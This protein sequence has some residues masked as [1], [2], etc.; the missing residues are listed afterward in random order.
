MKIGK[1]S[2]T[3]VLSIALTGLV[4]QWTLSTPIKANEEAVKTEIS[5]SGTDLLQQDMLPTADSSMLRNDVEKE[6]TET[7]QTQ[8]EAEKETEE[9]AVF[10]VEKRAVN[11]LAAGTAEVTDWQTFVEALADSSI[12]T[13]SL[14]NDIQ[15]TGTLNNYEGL[16]D[17]DSVNL[18]AGNAFLFVSKAAISRSLVIDGNGYTFDF[19]NL[20]IGFTNAATN[21]SSYWD[22]TL[23]NITVKSVNP[24]APFYYPVLP[25]AEAGKGMTSYLSNSRLT[26]GENFVHIK[27]VNDMITFFLAYANR[28]VTEI[29]LANDIVFPA[30]TTNLNYQLPNINNV[31]TNIFTTNSMSN[32]SGGTTFLYTNVSGAARAFTLE[33]NG[34]SMDFGT[35][36]L[37]TLNSTLND[38][39]GFNLRWH[40]TYQNINFFHGNYWGPIE[41]QDLSDVYEREC[42]Q[43]FVDV[44]DYGAQFVQA[45]ASTL[46]FGGNIH[47]EQQ[48]Y[49]R[50]VGKDGNPLRSDGANYD[51][52]T[53]FSYWRVNNSRNQTIGV[54]NV[55][56]EDDS[57]IFLSSIGGVVVDLWS[58][59]DMVIGK[60]VQMDAVR[61][62][63]ETS[64]EGTAAVFSLRGGSISIGEDSVV[65]L[66]SNHTSQQAVISLN[67]A[68]AA[69]DV[70]KG[71]EV[72]ILQTAN[73]TN[74]NGNTQNA[75]YMGGGSIN[76]NGALNVNGT[77]MG[78]SNSHMIYSNNNVSF[79]IAREGTLDIQSDSTSNDQRLIYMGGSGS[80]FQFSDAERVN[81]QR[82]STLT[83]G[84]STNNGLIYSGGSLEVSVQN[85][86]QWNLNNMSG[87]TTAD[88][89]YDFDYVPMSSMVLR[90]GNSYNPTI[91]SANSMT[92]ATLNSFKENFTTRGQQRVLFTRIPDPNV[93]IHSIS[94]DNPDDPGS[95]TVYGYAVP[96]TYIRLWEEALNGT[97]SAKEKGVNDTIE[98]PV[99]DTG[100]A[101]ET[102]DNFT[103]QA[104]SD[105]NWSYTISSGN[106]FTAGNVIHAYGFANLKSE[107]PTQVVLDKTPPT[108]TPVT[109]YISQGD[110]LPDPSAFVKDA[111]DT[112]PINT[113]FDYAYTDEAEAEIQRNTVGTHTIK[114]NV[115]DRAT[116]ADGNAAPNTAVIE[117]TLIV[118]EKASGITADDLEVAYVDIR[119]LTDAELAAYIL[120]NSQPEAFNIANG[121]FTDL[122]EYV[123]VSDFGGLNE[124]GNL[125][126]DTPYVVTLTVPANAE[127]GLS[128]PLTTTIQVVVIN[129]DAVLTVQFEDESGTVLSGYTLT[130]GEGQT[131]DTALNVGDVIDLTSSEFQAVQDQLT[132][133]ETAGYE[134]SVRPENETNFSITETAQTVTY[135]V[136]G[137]LFLKSAPSTVDFG[138]ITYNAKVQRVDNPSTDGDLVVTDTRANQADGWTLYAALT[139][140]MK[141]D[142][143]GSVMNEALWYVDS[144]G[145]EISLTLDSGNQPIYTNASGGTFDVTG[146]WGDTSADPGL[147]LVAD[148]TKTTVSSIGTYSGVVTWTIM[149]GQP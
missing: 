12:T 48:E 30:G 45:E 55:T 3:A 126:P 113:G 112:S 81:L 145:E 128:T 80:T 86:F 148:P 83:N 53:D 14:A 136:T 146:T 101:Q 10:P 110:D 16:F 66:T 1:K 100:M 24:Y 9:S 87:G 132:A 59:G 149:A 13:I 64:G 56:F 4:F 67:S 102:R 36:T 127:T 115:S 111:A 76:V 49:Y 122:T 8:E 78:S 23:Q 95:Y 2:L 22:I 74:G 119:D 37:C 121:T 141:N 103:V 68:S 26:Y 129:M 79:V 70:S 69:I 139:T 142:E 34:Y 18:A 50:S 92:N 17:K 131:I 105:G 73:S 15:L 118:Y 137:Q 75:I 130:I 35:V 93:S 147:K 25:Q 133:L 114:I 89:G 63:P 106:Y 57:T 120:A 11:L 104:D 40:Q 77:N 143:T 58:G 38:G 72:N 61:N 19:G 47:L 62:G 51:G 97:T 108:A 134:I 107:E 52:S 144:A 21:T 88:T 28:S 41:I 65:N 140:N 7:S 42:W 99:E 117:A 33:G 43:R 71:A 109:F 85:V 90:Y 138:S 116:D 27:S 54:S 124:Y 123:Q 60:N 39:S 94:N 98:S 91:T 32:S 31:A 84:T 20:A 29:N 125:Q 44:T 135:K 82:V 5:S 96:G 6:Q 46:Y